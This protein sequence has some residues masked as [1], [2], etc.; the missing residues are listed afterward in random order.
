MNHYS[1]HEIVYEIRCVV[2]TCEILFAFH[3][4]EI[5][6]ELEVKKKTIQS[7]MKRAVNKVECTD[8]FEILVCVR[9]MN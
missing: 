6:K 7:L 8:I 5:E 9:I 3:Y 1:N 2:I 4:V